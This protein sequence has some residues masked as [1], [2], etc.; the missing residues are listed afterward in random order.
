MAPL[1]KE[2]PGFYYDAEKNRYFP[3]P[4]SR[5]ASQQWSASTSTSE[6]SLRSPLDRSP[7]TIRNKRKHRHLL[8]YSGLSQILDSP[9]DSQIQG[10]IPDIARNS[11]TRMSMLHPSFNARQKHRQYVNVE[12][13]NQPR[14]PMYTKFPN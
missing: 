5:S 2:L 4:P 14:I 3:L 9:R 7:A 8:D 11:V 10:A 12:C 13:R 6:L 1:A